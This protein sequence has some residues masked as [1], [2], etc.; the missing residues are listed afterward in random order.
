MVIDLK[1]ANI[2]NGN[3]TINL[4]IIDNYGSFTKYSWIASIISDSSGILPIMN[5]I[6]ME[7]LT[8]LTIKLE[9]SNIK[10]IKIQY[11][12]SNND[13]DWAWYSSIL[14]SIVINNSSVWNGF[15]CKLLL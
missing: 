6:S 10:N 9:I 14:N 8:S 11:C 7:S 4:K 12:D 15:L 5:N 13:V 1:D 2:E 3:Y